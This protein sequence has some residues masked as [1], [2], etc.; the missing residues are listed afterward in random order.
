ML[1]VIESQSKTARIELMKA[2]EQEVFVKDVY[3]R[4]KPVITKS[5]VE[6]FKLVFWTLAKGSWTHI[7]DAGHGEEW[8]RAN[9]TD[10]KQPYT[11]GSFW[12]LDKALGKEGTY[13]VYLMQ[14]DDTEELT[15]LWNRF[16]LDTRCKVLRVDPRFTQD[17]IVKSI[18]R[19]IMEEAI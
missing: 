7:M 9:Q 10:D 15:E 1:V 4:T 13:I 19:Y 17:E 8:V 16:L 12:K 14:E 2:L 11:A 18:K 6:D 5:F 3:W